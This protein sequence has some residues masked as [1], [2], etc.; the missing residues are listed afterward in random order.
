MKKCIYKK[1]EE[2]YD[3]K[4]FNVGD[5]YY[6]ET[7]INNNE[8]RYKIY[9][10]LKGNYSTVPENIFYLLFNDMRANNLSK[11]NL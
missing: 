5:I 7:Y 10:D 2:Y 3:I 11:L 8:K 6:Y 4:H 9:H 1:S